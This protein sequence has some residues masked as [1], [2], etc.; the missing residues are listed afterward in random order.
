MSS[1]VDR[2]LQPL[3]AKIPS[4]IKYTT[5]F[6]NKLPDNFIL[7]TLDVAALYSSIPHN[8]GIEACKKYLD[9][10]ALLTTT[11]ADVC[12]MLYLY[13]KTMYLYIDVLHLST[14]FS[15][16][17]PRQRPGYYSLIKEICPVVG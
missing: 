7:V 10:I 6:F 9:K 15:C 14:D 16:H 1:F 8:N 13:Y 11:S 17:H 4:Y 2:E 3:M 12:N 5:D